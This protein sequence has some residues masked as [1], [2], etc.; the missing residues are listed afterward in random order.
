MPDI[1]DQ[2][3]RAMEEGRFENLSGQGHPL[4]L[5]ENP[6]EDPE[7]RLANHILRNAG[8]SLPWIE[9]RREVEADIESARVA[10]AQ[11]WASCQTSEMNPTLAQ[12]RWK[13]D[14]AVFRDAIAEINRRIFS[15]NLE[16]PSLQLQRM[17]LEPEKEITRIMNSEK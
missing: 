14:Q 16:V 13:Q 7:W 9:R 11:A 5:E 2:I 17:P 6:F 4:N 8:F 12:E 15:Y 1:E 3:R 10:L